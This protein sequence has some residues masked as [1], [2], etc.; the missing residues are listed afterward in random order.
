MPWTRSTYFEE[1]STNP[2]LEG[3]DVLT[4]TFLEGLISLGEFEFATFI[5]CLHEAIRLYRR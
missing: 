4:S 1:F 3:L 2:D 5:E